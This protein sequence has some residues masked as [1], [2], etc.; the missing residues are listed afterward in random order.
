MS[1]IFQSIISREL[2]KNHNDL[3]QYE[4]AQWMF[5]LGQVLAKLPNKRANQK[6]RECLRIG[7]RILDSV[8]D[9]HD[10]ALSNSV[11]TMNAEALAAIRLGEIDEAVQLELNALNKLDKLKIDVVKEQKILLHAH[12][13]D[14]NRHYLKANDLALQHYQKAFSLITDPYKSNSKESNYIIFRLT[15]ILLEKGKFEKTTKLLEAFLDNHNNRNIPK[16]WLLLAQSYEKRQQKSDALRN[17]L[18]IFNYC[19]VSSPKFLNA[20]KEYIIQNFQVKNEV[21]IEMENVIN[22]RNQAM[23]NGNELSKICS[24]YSRS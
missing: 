22:V 18:N 24:N 4:T 19:K 3:S 7:R 5:S 16:A 20:V 6:A 21:K 14:L 1:R 23:E 13:G 17:Y 9:G 10:K 15:E 2:S 12:V 8:N 11:A